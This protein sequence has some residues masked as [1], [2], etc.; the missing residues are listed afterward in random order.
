MESLLLSLLLAA[1]PAP[2]APAKL[3]LCESCHGRDGRART[4]DAP[5]LGGQNRAYL[6]Q[7]LQQYRDGRRQAQVMNGIAGVLS[8]ADI[9]ALARWYAAQPWSNAEP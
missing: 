7:A 6:A 1:A 9:E 5:H 3:G 2:P 4:P 8:P